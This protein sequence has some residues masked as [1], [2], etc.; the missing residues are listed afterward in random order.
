ML[1]E[2][3]NAKTVKA[4]RGDIDGLRAIA[5]ISVMMYHFSVWP[6][7]GGFVG[8]DVFFVISGYLITGGI[9]KENSHH[10]FSFSEFY[11][12][13]ARRLFPALLSTIAISYAVAFLAFSPTDFEKMSASTVFA[14]TGISNFYFWM[15]A[16][17][18]DSASILKPLLHTWSLSVELQFY[19]VWPIAIILL[20]KLGRIAVATGVILLTA[21][22]FALSLYAIMYDST[23][24]YY[25]TQYRFWEF[26]AGGLAF[27]F[28]RS[29]FFNRL[30]SLHGLICLMGIAL[31]LYPVF[32]YSTSTTFPGLNAIMPVIGS[33]M[34]ILSGDRTLGGNVLASRPASYIGEISYSLYLVHWPVVVFSQYILV[35]EFSGAS[36]L[37][38]IAA[39]FVLAIPMHRFIEKPLRKPDALKLSGAAFCLSCSGI[40]MAFMVPASTSWADKGWVWRL[41]EQIQ[42][43]NSLD[44]T[45]MQQYVASTENVLKAHSDFANNGKPRLL[46]IGDSQSAD[47]SNIMK[48]N[49]FLDKF[50]A[51]TRPVNTRCRAIFVN[52]NERERY[53]NEENGGTMALPEFIP[54]C[55]K[56]MNEATDP[57]I[58]KESDVI[59]IAMK[60]RDESLPKMKEAIEV[61]TK[62]SNA[63]IFL[64]GNKN[65]AKSSIDLVNTFGRVS[66]ISE[67]AAQNRDFISE[68]INKKISQ[69]S[70][71]TFVDMMKVVC[72]KKNS[73][74]VVTD[75]FDPI[76]FDQVH[77]TR[78]GAIYLGPK[79]KKVLSQSG[80][81]MK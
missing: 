28:R 46:I 44:I 38:L 70:G 81:E 45:S 57:H 42:K 43:I 8:V 23:G 37:L 5:V 13:R 33:M 59:F 7:T 36:G 56:Q 72:Q 54:M 64:F 52:Q 9:L 21:A 12:R 2:V 49:G 65:L 19:L 62:R 63:K 34:I 48:E 31:V 20:A 30:S 68:E 76:F 24:A 35:K 6:F 18:F 15:S 66:G 75:K 10:D 26:A 60:W 78:E 79:F 74:E 47:I 69:M 1:S 29:D 27:L 77:L 58:L 16:D 3:N 25:L 17:Y 41:P 4:Y 80:L 11:T 53:W 73:C 22:G 32:T 50:D 61:I 51:I 40:A 39:S 67:F 55:D 14:L 71:Y